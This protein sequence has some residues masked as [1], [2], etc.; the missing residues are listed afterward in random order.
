[1][2]LIQGVKPQVVRVLAV[3]DGLVR[4]EARAERAS[5]SSRGET[6]LPEFAQGLLREVGP[7][8]QPGG[9]PRIHV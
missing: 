2:L 3:C 1:M 7:D 4:F 9:P 5:W 8:F 6:A